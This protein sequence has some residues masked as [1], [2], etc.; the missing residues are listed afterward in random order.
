MSDYNGAGPNSPNRA[1]TTL[2]LLGLLTGA[3]VWG[4]LWYPYRV[5]QELGVDGLW[6]SCLSYGVATLAATLL[7]RRRAFRREYCTPLL[8]AITLAAGWTNLGYV[9]GIL[10]G[11]V[12]RVLLLFYLAP[13]W[14]VFLA[15]WWLNE[16]LSAGGYAVVALSLAGAFCMLWR[17]EGGWPLPRT[18][19]EWAGITAG[20]LFA[21]LNV[22][23]RKASD[24]SLEVKSVAV[25]FGVFGISAAGILITGTT[26]PAA[27]TNGD[28]A[29]LWVA[30]GLILTATNL[31]VQYGLVHTPAAR[32]VV[33]LLFELVIAGISSYV[34][35]QEIMSL[36][37]W[38]GG[39]LIIT[40]SLLSGWLEPAPETQAQ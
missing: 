26:W 36:K 21:V 27:A 37:E 17:P 28:A 13:L 40:A 24:L 18:A 7:Y 38:I 1:G 23:V 16:R 33:L 20:M 22:L 35:A 31:A 11:E 3:T 6:A 32:A 19:A 10:H 2:P 4:L 29:A 34:L 39:L 15:R 9:L 30:I 25:F 8:L 12:M 5:L 14:T